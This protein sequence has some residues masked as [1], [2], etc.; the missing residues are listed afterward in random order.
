MS[1]NFLKKGVIFGVAVC[2]GASLLAYKITKK[3]YFDLHK[4]DQ[5]G[6]VATQA[7]ECIF[8]QIIKDKKDKD[9]RAIL[10]EDELVIAIEDKYKM[11]EEHILIIPKRHIK[12]IYHLEKGD[13]S[14]VKHMYITG[15]EILGNRTAKFTTENEFR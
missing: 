8:C 2:I 1:N 5:S 9:G 7:P 4:Y 13:L 14:L 11:A 15:Q 3:L 10:Y 6:E 12:N